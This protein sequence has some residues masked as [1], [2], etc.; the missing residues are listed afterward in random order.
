MKKKERKYRM[1][2]AEE[3]GKMC[4]TYCKCNERW[5]ITNHEDPCTLPGQIRCAEILD[6]CPKCRM[7]PWIY[8][9]GKGKKR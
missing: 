1:I 7:F 3:S 4:K 8:P 9:F 6:K 2:R 5:D